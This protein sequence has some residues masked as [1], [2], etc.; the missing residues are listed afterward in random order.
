MLSIKT[1]DVDVLRS[2]SVPLRIFSSLIALE[3]NKAA[4][5]YLTLVIGRSQILTTGRGFNAYGHEDRVRQCYFIEALR[6]TPIELADLQPG[7]QPVGPCVISARLHSCWCHQHTA[8][9]DVG[10][11][12]ATARL[13]VPDCS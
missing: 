5:P 2:R 9:P 4:C 12:S 8:E 11:V 13:N 3:R 1:R 6:L 7:Y 10:Y